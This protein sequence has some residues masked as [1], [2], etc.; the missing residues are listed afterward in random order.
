VLVRKDFTEIEP[1]NGEHVV[2]Y[3]KP[4]LFNRIHPVLREVYEKRFHLYGSGM[5]GKVGNNVICKATSA[6]GFVTDL[7]SCAA[8]VG[9]AGNQMIGESRYFGKRVL[10]MPLKGQG[11][12]AYN[13]W[14]VRREGF[15]DCCE[16]DAITPS[17]IRGFLA[18]QFNTERTP[19]GLPSVLKELDR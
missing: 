1:T 13:A 5:T 14:H 7:A 6:T 17:V 3:I 18:S 19:N 11:E 4:P 10:A 16:I 15:G 8:V 2:V 9:C 12:Q